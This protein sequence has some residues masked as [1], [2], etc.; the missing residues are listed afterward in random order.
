[1]FALKSLISQFEL[2]AVSSSAYS[3]DPQQTLFWAFGRQLYYTAIYCFLEL[4]SYLSQVVIV[5]VFVYHF[6]IYISA[7]FCDVYWLR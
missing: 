5:T 7:G 4:L 6:Y 3:V 1:M 2:V